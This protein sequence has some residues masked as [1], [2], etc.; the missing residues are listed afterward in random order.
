MLKSAGV[1]GAATLG[2]AGRPTDVLEH[3]DF[4]M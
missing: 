1:L 4:K 2:V 3:L